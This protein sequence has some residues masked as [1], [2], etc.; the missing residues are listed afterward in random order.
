MSEDHFQRLPSCSVVVELE[1]AAT[2]SWEEVGE[3]LRALERE[4]RTVSPPGSPRKPRA[5]FVHG[6]AEHESPTLLAGIH[7]E[8]PR[9]AEVAE[10]RCLCVP[11]GR[12]YELKNAGMEQADGDVYVLLDSDAVPE[13]GWLPAL[14]TPFLQPEVIAANGH[15]YLGYSGFSSRMFALVWFFPL[16]DHEPR[17]AKR[18]ALNANSC[19]FRADWIR[20]NPFPIDNGFKV[21]CTKLMRNIEQAGAELIRVP[22]LARHAPLEGW[23][24]LAWRALVTGRDADRKFADLKST[25]RSKRLV[26]ALKFWLRSELRVTRRILAHYRHVDMPLWQVPAALALG[27]IFYFLAFCGQLSRL[28]GLAGDRP[29]YVPGFARHT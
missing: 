14:L 6:G 17:L 18:R 13:P 1:N 8:A 15:T 11:R 19:A 25:S 5:I 27:L 10:V 22:A 24:F 2:I 7:A 26:S 12:Y 9:L 16:R 20:A 21:S 29:E 3:S 28:T 23:R 4:I